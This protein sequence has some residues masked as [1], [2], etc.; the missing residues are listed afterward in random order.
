[1]VGRDFL[2]R[3]RV[4]ETGEP[5]SAWLGCF[6]FSTE[7]RQ[8]KKGSATRGLAVEPLGVERE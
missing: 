2:P 7:T 3:A 8:T 1:M 5:S 4:R 6:A